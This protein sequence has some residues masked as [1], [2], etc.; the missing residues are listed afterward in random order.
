MNI[1]VQRQATFSRVLKDGMTVEA[2]YVKKKDLHQYLPPA[3]L[4][5]TPSMSINNVK[6]SSHLAELTGKSSVQKDVVGKQSLEQSS[7]SPSMPSVTTEG[8]DIPH[9]KSTV[10]LTKGKCALFVI[11]SFSA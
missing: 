1:L 8:S 11:S 3:I 6:S 4:K 10:D 9:V 5:G 2:R 7:A